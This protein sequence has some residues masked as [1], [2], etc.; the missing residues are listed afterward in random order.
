MLVGQRGSITP[1]R[2]VRG[3][4]ARHLIG[5]QIVAFILMVGFS[6]RGLVKTIAL[7]RLRK[8]VDVGSYGFV[9]GAP[10]PAC[11][12][13]LPARQPFARA[14]DEFRASA[15]ARVIES[16]IDFQDWESYVMESSDW[17]AFTSSFWKFQPGLTVIDLG[18]GTRSSPHL[19]TYVRIWKSANDF[20]RHSLLPA[21]GPGA[22]DVTGDLGPLISGRRG[23]Q[24]MRRRFRAGIPRS[25]VFTFV[26]SPISHFIAG[27]NEVEYRWAQEFGNYSTVDIPKYCQEKGCVFHTFP[28]GS[29]DRVWAF[30]G[31]LLLGKLV[32]LRE[33]GHVYAQ[34]GALPK[35]VTLDFVGRL[36]NFDEDW[37]HVVDTY[38]RTDSSPQEYKPDRSLG[39]HNSA[40]F[41]AGE[42][43]KRLVND[44]H[45]F[46][47]VLEELL[48]MEYLC[49]GYPKVGDGGDGGD[50][51]DAASGP[52]PTS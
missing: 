37:R 28:M 48:L 34:L 35:R 3:C 4:R 31:D 39:G 25:K 5:V 23:G 17:R 50:G 52:S 46:V 21:A 29:T 42:A 51:G 10:S 24:T 15:P 19:V 40:N 36:E 13:P 16:S 41:E 2:F 12:R 18:D 30:L 47:G 22:I 33:V 20:I 9:D 14:L 32:G 45:G 27:Y 43:A 26:R 49:W 7:E 6:I 44:D 11:R 8:E 1:A 38:V